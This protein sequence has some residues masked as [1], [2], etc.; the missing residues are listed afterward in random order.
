M[1]LVRWLVSLLLAAALVLP[2]G[3]E[4][5]LSERETAQARRL[6]QA[7]AGASALD[8]LPRELLPVPDNARIWL[9]LADS[10]P[11]ERVVRFALRGM[12]R[13]SAAYRELSL[14]AD[15]HRVVLRH[16]REGEYHVL[17][18][19][20][21]AA[22]FSVGTDEKVLDAVLGVVNDPARPL[23]RS[24]A[25]YAL[26][27]HNAADPRISSALAGLLDDLE[28]PYNVFEALRFARLRAEAGVDDGPQARLELY[29]R[30]YGLLSHPHPVLRGT[31][32]DASPFLVPPEQRGVLAVRL[33]QCLK[34]DLHAYV[35]SQAAGALADLDSQPSLSLLL[36]LLQEDDCNTFSVAYPVGTH[37][38]RLSGSLLPDTRDAALRAIHQLSRVLGQ[39]GFDYRLVW[40]RFDSGYESMSTRERE[41]LEQEAARAAMWGEDHL[42]RFPRRRRVDWPDLSG[43]WRYAGVEPDVPD[44]NI[45]QEGSRFRLP[46]RL[47]SSFAV[48]L[49]ETPA[50]L[51]NSR[52]YAQAWW[53][54]DGVLCRITGPG[55]DDGFTGLWKLS[56]DG[57]TLTKEIYRRNLELWEPRGKPDLVRVYQRGERPRQ[58][59]EEPGSCPGK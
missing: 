37:R 43:T 2:A 28:H 41:M 51:P 21:R 50:K 23:F 18:A 9:Y 7:L 34:Q 52:L 39:D 33:E 5:S 36:P 24:R 3:A 44:E 16:L 4:L 38:T 8:K 13:I 54:G 11:D 45:V 46:W 14:E 59:S 22:T 40:G 12:A 25:L 27:R 1:T 15:Y 56:A 42:D 30:V 57:R 49:G 55:A 6:A 32:V 48:K 19:A 31:A 53:A 10:D 20:L 58:L 26:R 17:D 47:A 29:R 35:C